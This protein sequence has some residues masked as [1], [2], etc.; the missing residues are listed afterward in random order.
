MEYGN[1]RV[2][3]PIKTF[4]D[5]EVYQK[6][7]QMSAEIS[8]LQ[9]LGEKRKELA[10]ITEKI[11]RLIAESYGDKYDSKE[12]AHQKL[13]DAVTLITNIITKIDLLRETHKKTLW[14][15]QSCF[16]SRFMISNTTA[17]KW[18]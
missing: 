6:T 10:E 2:R 7:I 1:F 13:T 8:S 12:L 9:F 11:P 4:R 15:N 5:L 16:T 18:I 17:Q 3:S 14:K